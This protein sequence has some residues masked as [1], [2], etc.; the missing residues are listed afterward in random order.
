MDVRRALVEQVV[1]FLFHPIGIAIV[2][3]ISIMHAVIHI[4]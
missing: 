3:D 2:R 4:L 1:A